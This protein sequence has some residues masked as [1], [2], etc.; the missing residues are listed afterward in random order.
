MP[1]NAIPTPIVSMVFGKA[2]PTSLYLFYCSFAVMLMSKSINIHL[3]LFW[4]L[5]EDEVQFLHDAVTHCSGTQT[6]VAC[7]YGSHVI[8]PL[9]R[10]LGPHSLL[11]W[12]AL[13]LLPCFHR[14]L[15]R[16]EQWSH[17]NRGGC[18]QREQVSFNKVS[19]PQHHIHNLWLLFQ[20]EHQNW[21]TSGCA[22]VYTGRGK[23]STRWKRAQIG[24]YAAKRGLAKAERPCS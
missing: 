10:L 23:Y 18:V 5:C 20:Q 15:L 3:T 7:T 4:L 12:E 8:I 6:Y 13:G 24:K 9:P 1:H 22:K 17:P 11:H 16:E 21:S 14:H 19:W 2:I